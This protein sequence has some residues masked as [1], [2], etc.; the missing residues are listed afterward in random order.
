MV[1]QA[2]ALASV[3]ARSL[4]ELAEQAGGHDKIA[5]VGDELE[6]ICELTRADRKFR[7]LL[8]SPI[9]DR[10]KRGEALNQIFSNRITD[11]TLRFL[12][13]LNDRGRLAV[14]EAINDSFSDAMK[15]A[16]G[17]V[18]V[19]VY[20]PAPLGEDQRDVI[21]GRIQGAI[22]M[23]PILHQF[24]EPE[25]LGGIKLRIRDQLIDGSVATRLKRMKSGL[26]TNGP[27]AMRSR[28][29]EIIKDAT[30]ETGV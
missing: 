11:L 28:I 12:L 22:G 7:E 30:G 18:E 6:Q 27:A 23:E 24:T 29:A 15:E 9:I 10:R 8:A 4:F 5:E 19:N 26:L 20:T 21:R 16:F 14:L 2:N 13:L 1:T 3:Y 25:M 17:R